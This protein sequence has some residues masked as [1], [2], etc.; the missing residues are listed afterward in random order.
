MTG[1]PH[2]MAAFVRT[3]AFLRALSYSCVA[4]DRWINN[5][6]PA[7]TVQLVEANAMTRRAIA[8]VAS[9]LTL[10]KLAIQL[11]VTVLCARVIWINAA[12]DVASM[13]STG[14]E[15]VALFLAPKI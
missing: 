9:S 13:T 15:L 3:L 1:V 7:L 8:Y 2:W 4:R 14:L 6:R 10:V 5:S 11:S 12:L